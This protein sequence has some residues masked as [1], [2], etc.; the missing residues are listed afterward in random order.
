MYWYVYTL[1]PNSGYY[2]SYNNL[3]DADLLDAILKDVDNP[4]D[5]NFDASKPILGID[6]YDDYTETAYL[7]ICSHQDTIKYLT[8]LD[9]RMK[10]RMCLIQDIIN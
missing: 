9:M 4:F 7:T 1:E 10:V 2:I 8:I 5:R 3:T 6:Y